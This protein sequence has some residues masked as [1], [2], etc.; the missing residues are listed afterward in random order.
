MA[1][2]GE[3]YGENVRTITI[4]GEERF[5]YELCGGTHVPETGVIG[6]F[7]ILS[8]ESVAAGTRRI[9]AVTGR[10]VIELL[11]RT[12]ERQDRLAAL[13]TAPA[14]TL[15][16]QVQSLLEERQRLSA[17]LAGMRQREAKAALDS[18]QA[19]SFG[20]THLLAGIIPLADPEM[21]RRL[22]DP[23]RAAQPSHIVVLGSVVDGRPV[24]M[25]AVSQDLV[26]RGLNAADL[27]REA[28][29]AIGGSG[30]GRP[31]MA[32]AG[33]KIAEGLPQAVETARA[34]ARRRLQG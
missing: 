10:G 33:G 31:T 20:P 9:E 24:L 21:L 1:L 27:V 17:E 3:H 28:A 15:E 19:E 5:S 18:L 29:G 23:F 11:E 14:E 2:F 6:G 30:G 16:T 8:E 7:R 32:Q 26:Q 22:S 25:A 12:L 13:L 4:G 34:S